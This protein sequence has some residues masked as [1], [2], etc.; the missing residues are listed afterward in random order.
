M[1][2][3]PIGKKSNY[4]FMKTNTTTNPQEAH[5]IVNMKPKIVTNLFL[6]FL[7]MRMIAPITPK[8]KIYKF[9][10]NSILPLDSIIP[11]NIKYLT[12]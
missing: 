4:F 2:R 5:K 1:N 9:I 11:R 12:N 3:V 10:Y 7:F 8:K 6:C